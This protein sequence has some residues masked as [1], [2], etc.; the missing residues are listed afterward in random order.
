MVPVQLSYHFPGLP[1]VLRGF[2]SLPAYFLS[3]LLSVWV[4]P[5]AFV[6]PAGHCPASGWFPLFPLGTK[7][8]PE[9]I[10]C[11]YVDPVLNGCPIKGAQPLQ[12]EG[13][14]RWPVACIPLVPFTPLPHPFS[15]HQIDPGA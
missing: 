7:T 5:F 3:F 6:V 9:G 4:V 1:Q 10:F 8:L 14:G 13:I 12:V 11:L 2:L 15:G